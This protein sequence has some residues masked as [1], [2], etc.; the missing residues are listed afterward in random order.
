MA[1]VNGA[2]GGVTIIGRGGTTIVLPENDG[3]NP[4]IKSIAYLG[5]ATAGAPTDLDGTEGDWWWSG[6]EK[7]LY[8]KL[9]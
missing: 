6:T 7:K 2:T 5:G 3:D 8:R 9:S 1:D 4:I